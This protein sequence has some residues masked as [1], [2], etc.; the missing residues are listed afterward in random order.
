MGVRACVMTAAI[1]AGIAVGAGSGVGQAAGLP[2]N[3]VRSR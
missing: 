3:S 2:G 1:V